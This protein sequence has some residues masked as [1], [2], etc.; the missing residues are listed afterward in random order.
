VTVLTGRPCE[1]TIYVFGNA[2]IAVEMTGLYV[3]LRLFVEAVVSDRVRVTY[4]LPSSLM[5]VL[6]DLRGTTYEQE[7]R[8]PPVGSGATVPPEDRKSEHHGGQPAD[9]LEFGR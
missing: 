4:D 6:N 9:Q 7:K 1:A 8:R 5:N 2:L 3:P